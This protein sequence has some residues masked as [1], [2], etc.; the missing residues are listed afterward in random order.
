MVVRYGLSVIKVNGNGDHFNIF[1][2]DTELLKHVRRNTSLHG[3]SAVLPFSTKYQNPFPSNVAPI[4][5]IPKW[6]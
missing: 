1:V 6:Q 4:E 2:L 5:R 3:R